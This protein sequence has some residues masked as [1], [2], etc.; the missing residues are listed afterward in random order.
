MIYRAC[1]EEKPSTSDLHRPDVEEEG[2][3]VEV[4]LWEVL[5]RGGVPQPAILRI[6]W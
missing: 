5:G 3:D 4:T 2:G 1:K 6:A